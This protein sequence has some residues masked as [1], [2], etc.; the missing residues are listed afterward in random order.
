MEKY[1][2]YAVVPEVLS[3]IDDLTNW[4]IRLNRRR[5]WGGRQ[6]DQTTVHPGLSQ[7]QISAYETLY[8]VLVSFTKIFAPFAPF[9]SERV[10]LNLTESLSGVPSS[11]HL[12]DMPMPETEKIDTALEQRMQLVRKVTEL[13]RSLRAKHQLK[14]RQPLSSL[15][16]ITRNPSDKAAIANGH[17]LICDEL[18]VKQIDF[19]TDEARFV[20]LGVKPNLKTLGKKLGSALNTVKQALERV[21]ANP[22]EAAKLLYEVEEKGSV[23]IAGYKLELGD[24]LIERGPKDE[25]LIAT[26]VGITVLLDTKLTESLIDEGIAREFVNRIQTLRK[27]SNLN[28]SDRIKVTVKTD[29]EPL[30]KAVTGHSAYIMGETLA[31]ALNFSE[32]ELSGEVFKVAT[33]VEGSAAEISLVL[34]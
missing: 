3:F 21:S 16:V 18:N 15:M 7:D 33:E 13:G 1:H 27:D 14:T 34:A 6:S 17:D 8:C 30:R 9:I 32:T 22:E 31:T 19:S 26:E 20:K 24:F 29:S 23:E 10:Y 5:F 25:R 2:L 28:V 4:Y 11:V 12:C